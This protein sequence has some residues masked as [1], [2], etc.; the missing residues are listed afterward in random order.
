MGRNLVEEFIT[1]DYRASVKRVLDDALNGHETSN[2]EFPLV[3]AH[4]TRVEVLLNATTRVASSGEI[5]GVVGIGQDITER[6]N[7]ELEYV[8][9]I[10]TANAPIF[11]IDSNGLVN[12]WNQK[13]AEV[14]GFLK[15]EVIGHDL[16]KEFI[17]GQY[18]KAVSAVLTN[19]LE[20]HDTANYELPFEHKN[21][22]TIVVLLN[23]SARRDA[24]SIVVGVIGVGQ[25]ITA[26]KKMEQAKV[27]FLASF[28]HELRTPL[29]GLLGMLELLKD[30][31]LQKEATRY[32]EFA[33]TSATLLLN[34]INDI[35]DLSKI[36]A[37]K[38]EVTQRPFN[39]EP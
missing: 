24:N 30:L 38:L 22:A 11:G 36:E 37:G 8:K 1:P 3:T 28:S 20:G 7:Q 21:H 16:V 14:T 12:E 19:A 9:L 33:F 18:Q 27:T 4:G 23:A 34:L 35:L 29:N 32:I 26:R 5:V 15:E 39:G 13:I 31:T 25:D 17:S 6:K 10:D 2:F